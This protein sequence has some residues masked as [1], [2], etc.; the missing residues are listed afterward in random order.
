MRSQNICII[1]S[2]Q[3]QGSLFES[4]AC[5][6]HGN[7]KTL[8]LS[9]FLQALAMA[10]AARNIETWEHSVLV[11]KYAVR[12][13][14]RLGLSQEETEQLRLGSLLHDIGKIGISDAV[15]LKPCALTEEEYDKIKKHPEIGAQI[16]EPARA[17]HS[18]I[19]IALHHHEHFN[20]KGYPHGLRGEK[21]PFVARIVSLADAFEA[22]TSGRLY[23][24]EMSFP[25]A[26]EE[27]RQQSGRQ[28]DP[29]LGRAFVEMI[30]EE[31]SSEIGL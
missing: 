29:C 14:L 1:D 20:G 12:F 8:S 23:R 27:I 6:T 17:L 13:G 4:I 24:Q 21:I 18:I 10:L 5:V 15:L 11:M 31:A 16:L 7:K 3:T 28:F 19:P 25:I 2:Y 26:L 30:S 22:M 9:E